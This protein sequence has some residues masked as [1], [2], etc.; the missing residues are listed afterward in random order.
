MSTTSYGHTDTHSA[1]KRRWRTPPELI[2]A[3]VE[4]MGKP[5]DLDASAEEPTVAGRWI[6][7]PNWV[8]RVGSHCVGSDCLTTNWHILLPDGGDVWF[9]PPWGAELAPCK[10]SKRTG[11]YLC[12]FEGHHT[13]RDRPVP[14][15]MAYVERAIEMCSPN[16]R[17]WMLV[18]NAPDTRWW[19]LAFNAAC[20]VRHLPRVSFLDPDTGEALT[21]PPGTGVTLFLLGPMREDPRQPRCKLATVRGIEAIPE[22]DEV[23]DG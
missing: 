6:S 5:F 15:T 13:H 9:N 23:C 12:T 20:E 11:A 4:E 16:L 21:A 3:L 18:P 10:R 17:V 7:P 22:S 8:L 14:G 1:D 2:A 19:R